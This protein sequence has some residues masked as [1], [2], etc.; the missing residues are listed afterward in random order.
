MARQIEDLQEW[1]APNDWSKFGD[2]KAWELTRGEDFTQTARQARAAF[3][4]WVQ[5]RGLTCRVVVVD[6]NTLRV[7]TFEKKA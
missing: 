4:K 1:T 5:R 7:Q 2:G 6:D 3:K